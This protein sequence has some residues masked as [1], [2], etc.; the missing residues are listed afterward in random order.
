M[1]RRIFSF[2][3]LIVCFG[4]PV[5][6]H[7]NLISI[8]PN[9]DKT[10]ASTPP[11]L[12][13]TFTEPVEPNFSLMEV[14]DNQ[15]NLIALPPATVPARLPSSLVLNTSSLEAGVYTV[16]WRV[17]SATDGHPSEGSFPLRIGSN[18]AVISN[19]APKAN[20]IP[21]DS[22]ALRAFNLLSLALLMGAVAF[23]LLIWKPELNE[24]LPQG[25]AALIR[26]FRLAWLLF[27]LSS[28]G[29]LFMQAELFA[30]SWQNALAALPNVLFGTRFGYFW[31]A[32]LVLWLMLGIV[33]NG[34]SDIN[35]SGKLHL[36]LGLALLLVQSLMSHASGALDSMAAVAA[37]WLHLVAMGFWVGGLVAFFFLL[38][39]LRKNLGTLGEVLAR[40]SNMARLSVAM[41]ILTGTYSAWLHVGSLDALITTPYGQALIVKLL[42]FLPL[43][44]IGAVNLL[45]T[46]RGLRSGN[47]AWSGRLRGLLGA[48]IALTLGI[49]AAVGSMTAVEPARS[50]YQPPAPPPQPEPYFEM[51]V[52]N[53]MM[54]HL[55]IEPNIVGQNRFYVDLF[56]LEMSEP[57]DDASSVMLSFE[58]EGSSSEVEA[59]AQGGGRYLVSGENLDAAG[60]WEIDV[61]I[62]RPAFATATDFRPTVHEPLPAPQNLSLLSPQERVTAM[63]LT[64]LASLIISFILLRQSYPQ[65]PM[66]S[67][68]SL[69]AS[70]LIASGGFLL[71]LPQNA[72][73][74]DSPIKMVMG[75]AR[76]YLLTENGQILQPSENGYSPLPFDVPANDL[77]VQSNGTLWIATNEGLYRDDGGLWTLESPLPVN[78]LV[79]QH[80]FL[81]ALGSGEIYRIEEGNVVHD[82]R[83]LETPLDAPASDFVM[84]GNHSHVL[85]NGDSVY[86]TSSVGLGWTPLDAPV[87]IERIGADEKGNLLALSAGGFWT[88]NWLTEE[89]TEGESVP[90]GLSDWDVFN[91][92]LYLL[93][94]GQV[95][96]EAG[97]SWQPITIDG[98]GRFVDIAYQYPDSLWLLE[99]N[100]S[101]WRQR[102]SDGLW[103]KVR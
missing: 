77:L 11:E 64:G 19:L 24:S 54:I 80:G 66:L 2:I 25:E 52:Q 90:A 68:L 5:L 7:S 53:G 32:R 82:S 99:E 10:L 47:F 67:G 102:L 50:A 29:I 65:K 49:L 34:R 91:G 101:L 56:N 17:V 98:V 86:S 55:T 92:K 60:E 23:P 83:S 45:L 103:N 58:H 57:L 76:P 37:D 16:A 73:P 30:G 84:M 94:D 97:D 71:L 100:G 62:Q 41:L 31:L 69:I 48:E 72:L 78:N 3:L 12:M 20:T 81:L 28:F 42:L 43:L 51:A 1:M 40:F 88:W 21:L 22:A 75:A 70:L 93:A 26:Y 96:E 15:G 63:L 61:T 35:P 95:Y 9:V 4:M 79:S 87:S 27:G 39:A 18:A 14:Y 13:M 59:I 36:L 89:W 44:A 6:A 38:G 33:F 85:L 46:E 8:L 74:A